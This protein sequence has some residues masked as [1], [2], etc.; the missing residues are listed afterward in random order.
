M[1]EVLLY[2]GKLALCLTHVV[3]CGIFLG[4]PGYLIGQVCFSF[5][6][7][8]LNCEQGYCSQIL[9]TVRSRVRCREEGLG[10]TVQI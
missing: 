1:F 7:F 10:S 6:L 3:D 9:C 8:V 2:G 4:H 5:V